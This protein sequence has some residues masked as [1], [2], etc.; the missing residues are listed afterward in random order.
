MRFGGSE[1]R[2]CFLVSRSFLKLLVFVD[3]WSLPHMENVRKNLRFPGG[4]SGKRTSLPMQEMQETWVWSLVW[5]YLLEKETQ[6]SPVFL[7]GKS[8]G[9]RSLVSYMGLQ[10]I[11][12]DWTT[13]HWRATKAEINHV[14]FIHCWLLSTQWHISYAVGAKLFVEWNQV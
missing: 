12:H 2:V 9:Q 10:R 8:H 5:E 7:L 6:P 14:Y 4:T 13:E 11:R 3:S 1:E